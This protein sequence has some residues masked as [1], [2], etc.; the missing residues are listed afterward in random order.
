MARLLTP[1]RVA[2]SSM[3]PAAMRRRAPSLTLW[4]TKAEF[5]LGYFALGAQLLWSLR[6]LIVLHITIFF[7][8]ARVVQ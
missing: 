8:S 7:F 3:L 6:Q 4:W 5:L 2:V 1:S